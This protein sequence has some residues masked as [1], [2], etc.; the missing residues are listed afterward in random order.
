MFSL[1]GYR[2][3]AHGISIL[4]FL[5]LK[6]SL[7]R[8]L[9][10]PPLLPTLVSIQSNKHWR[11][12]MTSRLVMVAHACEPNVCKVAAGDKSRSF[13]GPYRIKACTCCM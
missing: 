5:P 8:S 7:Q 1:S 12:S 2:G 10:L 4:E 9:T 3:L 13:F 6:G 11:R